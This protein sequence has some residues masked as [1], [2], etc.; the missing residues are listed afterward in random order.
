MWR[1]FIIIIAYL[2]AIP[3]IE[4]NLPG[5]YS[6]MGLSKPPPVSS[7]LGFHLS[8]PDPLSAATYPASISAHAWLLRNDI[9]GCSDRYQNSKNYKAIEVWSHKTY[10]SLHNSYYGICRGVTYL[11]LDLCSHAVPFS[12]RELH[13]P[14]LGWEHAHVDQSLNLCLLECMSGKIMWRTHNIMNLMAGSF[15]VV[16]QH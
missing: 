16:S 15:W 14:T 7:M 10:K 8:A 4:F 6:C 9:M 13:R 11:A 12:T 2:L 5:L 3:L 1:A